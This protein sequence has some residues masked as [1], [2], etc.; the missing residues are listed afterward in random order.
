MGRARATRRQPTH[1]EGMGF[2]LAVRGLV[3][4]DGQVLLVRMNYGPLKGQWVAPGGLVN[5]QETILEAAAREVL[6]ESGV[7]MAPTGVL[8]LRH[9]VTA[10]QNNLLSLV[11]GR[12]VSGE[13]RPDGRETDAA[14]FLPP[15]EALALPNLYPVARLAIT[16]SEEEGPALRSHDGGNPHFQFLLP[17]GLEVPAALVPNRP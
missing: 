10:S 14:A 12:Y 1:C 8:A 15:G 7:V 2:E 11:S 17:A 16:L 13:P 9:Y 5:Q 6:E 3:W 4:R